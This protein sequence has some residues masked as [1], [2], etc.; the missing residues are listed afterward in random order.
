MDN[1]NLTKVTDGKDW[2]QEWETLAQELYRVDVVS[3]YSYRKCDN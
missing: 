2:Y 1:K 3:K